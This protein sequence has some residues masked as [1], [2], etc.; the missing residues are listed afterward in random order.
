MWSFPSRIL[1]RRR[2]PDYT[3]PDGGR[4]GGVGGHCP[5][6]SRRDARQ[7]LES[8]RGIAWNCHKILTPLVPC[9]RSWTRSQSSVGTDRQKERLLSVTRVSTI[10]ACSRNHATKRLRAPL[11]SGNASTICRAVQAAVGC[12]VEVQVDDTSAVVSEHD[13]DEGTRKRAA[14][15]MKKSIETQVPNMVREQ[16]PPGLERSATR[17]G[18]AR[19]AGSTNWPAD[20][21]SR[22][23]DPARSSTLR[24][25]WWSRTGEGSSSRGSHPDHDGTHSRTAFACTGCRTPAGAPR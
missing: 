7:P 15:P 13:K 8:S 5:R 9:D 17:R 21:I 23:A 16:R 4:R 6:T 19:S 2:L 11:S 10:L 20:G 18:R 24:G 25:S 22:R 3:G 12:S 1:H 14:G